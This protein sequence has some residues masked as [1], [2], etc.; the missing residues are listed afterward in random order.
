MIRL[1]LGLFTG[2]SSLPWMI[3]GIA[4]VVSAF[5]GWLAFHDNNVWNEATD[6]FNKKQEAIVEQKQE[7]FRQKTTEIEDN[8]AR[9]R[10]II[11]ESEKKTDTT[12]E[13]IVKNAEGN[14]SSQ[15]SPYLKSIV[16]QLDR[17]YGAKK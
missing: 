13:D 12:V 14:G 16:K 10:A 4:A 11:A 15:S 2:G 3:V 9:I 6:A 7:E 17:A 5:F 1:V 8:A